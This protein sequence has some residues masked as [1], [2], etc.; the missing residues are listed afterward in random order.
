MD[1]PIELHDIMEHTPS[2]V[3]ETTYITPVAS[4]DEEN[5]YKE[6][7]TVAER[8]TTSRMPRDTPTRNADRVDV[9][10]PSTDASTLRKVQ[11]FC[12]ILL[13]MLVISW[14]TIGVLINMMVRYNLL[15]LCSKNVS[16]PWVFE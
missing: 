7:D 16:L 10:K 2:V 5:V 12:L 11:I 15:V 9:G 8:M 14:A 6:M 13:V 3:D 1:E 4:R